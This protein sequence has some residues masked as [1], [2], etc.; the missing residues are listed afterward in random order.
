MKVKAILKGIG[1]VLTGTASTAVPLAGPL[2]DTVLE[3]LN[4]KR[5]FNLRHARTEDS[6]G[7]DAR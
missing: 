4:S 7:T 1:R 6:L 5:Q 3:V 2:V